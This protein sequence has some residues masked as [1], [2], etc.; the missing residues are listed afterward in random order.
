M[1][2][3]PASVDELMNRAHSLVGARLDQL[4]YRLAMRADGAAVST[5][6][7]AGMLLEAALGAHGGSTQAHDFP[8]IGVE[9]KSIPVAPDGR[10]LESTYVCTLS[11]RDAE[12]QEWSSSW[13]RKKLSRVLFVPLIAERRAPWA[14]RVVGTPLLWSPTA[15]QER[16]LAADFDEAIGRIAVGGIED[17]DA[18]SGR[19]MQV[20]PKARDGAA[21]TL[22]WD[23]DG[24]PVATVPRG[25]YLRARFTAALLVDPTAEPD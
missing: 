13:A 2:A 22:A 15:G 23:R 9:L 11:I 6:G 20:R 4:A 24:E 25:F 14:T 3:P 8:E 5:K 16:G 7:N 18:R 10:V 19:W 17:L 12:R 21:R 1:I